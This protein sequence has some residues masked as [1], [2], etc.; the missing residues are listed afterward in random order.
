M[1]HTATLTSLK[2]ILTDNARY[3]HWAHQT[4]VEWLRTKP[5]ELLEKE[6][7]S[8]FSSLRLT[9]MHIWDVEQGWHGR[10][11][12]QPTKSYTWEGFDGTLEDIL[13]DIVRQSEKLVNYIE[14]LTDEELEEGCYFN[15]MYVG[16]HTLPRREIIQHS[17]V[18]S[19]Y[20]R[21]QLITIGRNLGFTDAPMTDYMFYLLRVKNKEN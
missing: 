19:A 17:L 6:V 4:L 13:Q 3:N 16:E 11:V 2:E 15:I 18:H 1:I 12:G 20:H 8:S 10:L 7:P 14:G 9:L 21:G 5:V